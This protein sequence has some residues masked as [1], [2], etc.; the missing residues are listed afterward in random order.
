MQQQEGVRFTID[1]VVPKSRGGKSTFEN[2]VTSCK[3]CNHRK[4]HRSCQEV[5]MF[6]KTSLVAPT[7]SEFLR[8]KLETLGIKKT[9]DDIFASM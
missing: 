9:L 2:C 5:K 1:H 7:I 6:P 8:L 3:P 4:G